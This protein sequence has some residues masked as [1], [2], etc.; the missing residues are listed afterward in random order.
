MRESADNKV[1]VVTRDNELI[2]ITTMIGGV[3]I[4]LTMEEARELSVKLTQLVDIPPSSWENLGE[5]HSPN[6]PCWNGKCVTCYGPG[7]G[8]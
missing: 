5:V 7:V 8:R 3:S 1:I 4:L 6:N 2:K